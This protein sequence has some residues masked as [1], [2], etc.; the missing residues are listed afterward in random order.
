MTARSGQRGRRNSNSDRETSHVQIPVPDRRVRVP[1]TLV[2]AVPLDGC[3]RR[4][5]RH[6]PSRPLSPGGEHGHPRS[7]V[8][9]REQSDPE[10]L[11]CEP[12]RRLGAA[13]L[14]RTEGAEGHGSAISEGDRRDSR[15]SRAL[16]ASREYRQP[17]RYPS[18]QSR[19]FRRNRGYQLQ[20]R[21]RESDVAHHERSADCRTA[22]SQCWADS[23]D[24]RRRALAQGL[25]HRGDLQRGH[26]R[27]H[28]AAHVRLPSR[29]RDAAADRGH[30]SRPQPVRDH[31][32]EQ[33]ARP[34]HQHAVLGTHAR[35]RGRDRLRVVHCLALPRGTGTGTRAGTRRQ[36][37][38]R[39]SGVGRRVRGPNRHHRAGRTGR[40][41]HSGGHQD[42]LGRLRDGHGLRAGRAHAGS[43]TS[44]VLATCSTASG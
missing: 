18:G 20:G 15:R 27:D 3:A 41:R 24:W 38:D 34:V 23:R 30:R 9:E 32:A 5:G 6:R 43:R 8:P 26:R 21:G 37:G 19:R 29:R 13:R 35:P 17:D 33:R 2:R 42:G 36:D 1:E 14:R 25:R 22:R 11:S 16:A 28:P 7:R 4:S 40:G 12:E 44:R 39:N 31:R 10:Q